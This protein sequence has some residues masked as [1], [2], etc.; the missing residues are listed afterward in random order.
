MGRLMRLAKNVGVARTNHGLLI[1]L[2]CQ[3]N[4]RH[5]IVEIPIV[6]VAAVAVHPYKNKSSARGA[7]Q[8]RNS[9]RIKVIRPVEAFGAR[10]V[11]VVTYP[12]VEGQLA[13]DAPVVLDIPGKIEILRRNVFEVLNQIIAARPRSKQQRRD[14]VARRR[15]GGIRIGSLRHRRG[16]AKHSL[17][18]K[19]GYAHAVQ[20]AL[21]AIFHRVLATDLGQV[22]ESRIAVECIRPVPV[23]A[24]RN[25]AAGPDA[26]KHLHV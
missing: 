17:I 20:P 4:P 26:R 25:I 19:L 24:K 21:K 16:E 9:I 5:K 6:L 3:A 11:V 10:R 22:R 8:R 15:A 7:P 14:T 18:V 23:T 12:K 2:V 1:E 13:R